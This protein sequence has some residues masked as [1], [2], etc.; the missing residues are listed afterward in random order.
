M[1]IQN[2]IEKLESTVIRKTNRFVYFSDGT[3]M[4][5]ADF[6]TYKQDLRK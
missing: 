1:E 6:H 5:Y 2:T 3:H 4:S